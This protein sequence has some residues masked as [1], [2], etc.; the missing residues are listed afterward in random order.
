MPKGSARTG[1][2]THGSAFPQAS[3]AYAKWLS[4]GIKYAVMNPIS[5]A[6]AKAFLS[7]LH[8]RMLLLMIWPVL[9]ALAIWT[10]LAMLFWTQTLSWLVE[11]VRSAPAIESV[12]TSWSFSLIGL[13]YLA[14]IVLALIFVPAVLIT[15]VLI[16]GVF[17][18]PAM[19]THVAERHY[20]GLVRRNGGGVVGSAWNSV[21]ALL[22][23]AVLALITLPLWLLPLLWPA[24]PIL[25]FAYLSQRVFRYDALAEHASD[26]EMGAIISQNRGALFTLGI[27]LSLAS[28]IPILGFFAPVYA[29]L[30]FI[31]YCLDRLAQLRAGPIDGKAVRV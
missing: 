19:V 6:L 29:G 21:V 17:A 7:L 24:L 18:M 27:L 30:V 1:L 9:L 8:P 20:P 3:C 2:C 12:I 4:R 28:H 26:A 13:H 31:H 5:H 23:F 22:I 11:E 25:L 14:W 16:I 15:A 10:G